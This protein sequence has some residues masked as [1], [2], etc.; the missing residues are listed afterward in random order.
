[1]PPPTSQPLVSDPVLA[2]LPLPEPVVVPLCEPFAAAVD[3]PSVSVSVFALV[4]AFAF[5]LVFA[6]TVPLTPA[7]VVVDEVAFADA[8]AFVDAVSLAAA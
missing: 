1:M 8:E 2:R 4:F 3:A 5:V 7:W 6:L